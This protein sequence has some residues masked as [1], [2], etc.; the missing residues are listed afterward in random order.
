[1]KI[2]SHRG[3]LNGP[4]SCKENDPDWIEYVIDLGYD[5]EV[6]IWYDGGFYLGHDKPEYKINKK[7]LEKNSKF[8]WIHCKNQKA[9]F[10]LSRMGSQYNYFWHQN[11]YYTLTS[12][13]FIWVYPNKRLLKY[14]ICVLPELGINGRIKECYA[15]CTDFVERYKDA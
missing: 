7:W 5:V 4:N 9:L 11:D 2:I 10:E 3:N 8:L 13:S 15:I 14:S 6:D 12:K 1:V